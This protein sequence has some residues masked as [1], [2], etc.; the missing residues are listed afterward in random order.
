MHD[1]LV[2]GKW[3]GNAYQWVLKIQICCF[4]YPKLIVL[5]C[6]LSFVTVVAFVFLCVLI[7]HTACAPTGDMKIEAMRETIRMTKEGIETALRILVWHLNYY[8]LT[9][10]MAIHMQGCRALYCYYCNIF[11]HQVLSKVDLLWLSTDFSTNV[12]DKNFSFF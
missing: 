3:Q 10:P 1:V 12:W 8:L 11:M 2:E 6:A 9:K 5:Y 4:V 7:A